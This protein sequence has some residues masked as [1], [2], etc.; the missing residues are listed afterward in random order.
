M[1]FID[2]AS[3]HGL[4]IDRLQGDNCWHRVRTNDKPHKRN[5]CYIFDGSRGAL[6]NWATMESFATWPDGDSYEPL[7]L[8]AV[9]PEC[10]SRG[11]P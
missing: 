1:N 2:Y 11:A 3:V 5:G 9:V 10:R 4:Q 7:S 8:P 6:K